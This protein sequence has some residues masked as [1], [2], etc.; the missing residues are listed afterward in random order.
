MYDTNVLKKYGID[1]EKCEDIFGDIDTYNE[2]L[3]SFLETIEERVNSINNHLANNDMNDYMIEVHSLKSDARYLGFDSLAKITSEIED[4]YG[5]NDYN[6]IKSYNEKIMDSVRYYV[7]IARLYFGEAPNQ[8][9]DDNV[10]PIQGNILENKNIDV[11]VLEEFDDK[12]VII[13]TTDPIENEDNIIKISLNNN[14][15]SIPVIKPKLMK[16]KI[17]VVDDSALITKF[18]NRILSKDYDIVSATN[19]KEAIRLLDDENFRKDLKLCLLDLNMPDVDGYQVL[20]YCKQNDYFKDI[21]IAIE[22]GVEDTQ[23]LDKIN[24]YPIVGILLKPFKETDLQRIVEKS[25]AT[26]F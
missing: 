24:S 11:P 1:L 2:V 20:E 6:I 22:S 19:G 16:D 15:E 7:S 18:I 14:D 25:N 26:Y 10:N 9:L 21:P 13:S 8:E 23:N 17:L 12:P 4:E 3:K 5:K